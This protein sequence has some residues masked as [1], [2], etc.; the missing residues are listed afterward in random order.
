MQLVFDTREHLN[1]VWKLAEQISVKRKGYNEFIS[2][3]FFVSI[4]HCDAVQTLVEKK[5]FASAFSLVRPTLE[6]TFRAVWL[7][8]CANKDQANRA[9]YKSKWNAVGKNIELIED[10]YEDSI[11]FSKLWEMLKPF[12]HD[13]THGGS[14]LTL[15]HISKDGFITPTVDDQEVR[16]LLQLTVLVSTFALAELVDLSGEKKFEAYVEKLVDQTCIKVFGAGR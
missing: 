1:I 9:I 7:R 3:M 2:A 15:R 11:L 12:V 4:S 10:Q 6:N 8:K 13:F 16:F 5:N 14:E